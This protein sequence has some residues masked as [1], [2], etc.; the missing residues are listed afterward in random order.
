[1]IGH[2]LNSTLTVYR[3]SYTTDAVGGRTRSF[4]AAGTIRAQVSQPSAEERAVAAQEG[5]TLHHVV[6]TTY[7][8][9]VQR[10]DELDDGGARRLRVLAVVHDSR[11]TYSRLECEVVQGE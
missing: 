11:M 9:D 8:A 10:G 4:V 7:G 1:M 2:R 3:A 5:A 6:H